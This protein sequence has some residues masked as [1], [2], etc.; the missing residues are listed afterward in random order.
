MLCVG[1]SCVQGCTAV[2][3]L[4][5]ASFSAVAAQCALW[6]RGGR[7]LFYKIETS[8]LLFCSAQH[9]CT[10]PALRAAAA[11]GDVL[12][13]ALLH[14]TLCK[15]KLPNNEVKCAPHCTIF[16]LC[17]SALR[18]QQRKEKQCK[19]SSPQSIPYT[20]EQTTHNKK[21]Y[22]VPHVS[23]APHQRGARS[24]ERSA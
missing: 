18:Q 14:L 22:T 19:T 20:S 6:V 11:E 1:C 10:S 5:C 3:F 16:K 9:P 17:T 12:C 8:I 7:D 21:T 24:I 13:S 4:C 2:R 15:M 23:Q